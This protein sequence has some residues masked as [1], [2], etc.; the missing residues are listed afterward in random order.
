MEEG[1]SA[2]NCSLRVMF[3]AMHAGC[4]YTQTQT[5]SFASLP[6]LHA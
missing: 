6:S 3:S 1:K 5:D 4:V 2:L